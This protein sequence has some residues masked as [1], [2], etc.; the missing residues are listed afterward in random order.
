MESPTPFPTARNGITM[1]EASGSEALGDRY[2][3]R[4]F[5]RPEVEIIETPSSPPAPSEEDEEEEEGKEP[6]DSLETIEV[7]DPYASDEEEPKKR[8]LP[9]QHNRPKASGMGWQRNMDRRTADIVAAASQ[10]N[11]TTPSTSPTTSP[12][13]LRYNNPQEL[14]EQL[15]EWEVFGLFDNDSIV[16]DDDVYQ[17]A[18]MFTI[19]E[20]V[21]HLNS[22][23]KRKKS[24]LT[25]TK[26]IT[27]RTKLAVER[28]ARRKQLSEKT[29]WKDFHILQQANG[30]T[31]RGRDEQRKVAVGGGQVFPGLA[32][33][34]GY[35]E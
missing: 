21:E 34:R 25:L 23:S 20:I 10:G 32:G 33:L 5:V 27:A 14:D 8:R 19:P 9:Y 1:R 31:E 2:T 11:V 30:V 16:M 6:D 29:M 12:T 13:T 17:V 4:K 15:R 28:L 3:K 24:V 7:D 18:V 35:A 22:G 26:A